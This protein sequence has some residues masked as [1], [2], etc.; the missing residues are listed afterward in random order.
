MGLSW[1]QVGPSNHTGLCNRDSG[2]VRGEA[3]VIMGAEIGVTTLNMKEGTP[4]QGI[5][6]AIRS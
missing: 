1:I 2:G 4:R 5:Q 3:D 6:A